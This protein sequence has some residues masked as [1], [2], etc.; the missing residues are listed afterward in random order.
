M[1]VCLRFT[2]WF[3]GLLSLHSKEKGPLGN[4]S[5]NKTLKIIIFADFALIGGKWVCI[6]CDRNDTRQREKKREVR[7]VIIIAHRATLHRTHLNG[8]R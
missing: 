2:V 3:G 5:F 4:T 6:E 7:R 1:R 8:K